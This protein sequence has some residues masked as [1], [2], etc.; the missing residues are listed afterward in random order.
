[1]VTVINSRVNIKLVLF[2]YTKNQQKQITKSNNLILVLF[3]ALLL[4]EV[5][6]L[7]VDKIEIVL[8]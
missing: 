3:N 5:A 8:F 1:V 2:L 6:I 4:L 7:E